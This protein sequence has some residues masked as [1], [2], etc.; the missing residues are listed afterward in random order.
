MRRCAHS[1]IGLS[2]AVLTVPIVSLVHA[3]LSCYHEN[4][5]PSVLKLEQTSN[6]VRAYLGGR[7]NDYRSGKSKTVLY[8]P[9][10]GWVQ[11]PDGDC[12]QGWA[13]YCAKEDISGCRYNIPE[14]ALC[15]QAKAAFPDHVSGCSPEGFEQKVSVCTAHAGSVYFGIS[16]YQGEGVWGVG[17]VGRYD[18]RTRQVEIQRPALLRSS[19]INQIVHDGKS[20]WLGTT[21]HYECIGLPPTVGLVQL[22]WQSG[23]TKTRTSKNNN[24]PCGF[25]VH[26]LISTGEALWVATDLGISVL[27]GA[28]FSAD[29]WRHFVPDLGNGSIMR[30]T[31]CEALYTELLDSLPRESNGVSDSSYNLLVQNLKKFRSDFLQAYGA[32]ETKQSQ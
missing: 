17:G 29:A 8:S 21:G 27:G 9:G 6:G 30:E 24:G 4:D 1:L 13:G 18:P 12:K 19:S 5:F 7:H 2:L 23:S 32:H 15:E 28:G 3:A 26:G 25:V 10:T 14:V 11:G 20:L 31:T 16:F 22:Q